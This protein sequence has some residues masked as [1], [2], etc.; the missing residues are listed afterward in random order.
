V[1]VTGSNPYNYTLTGNIANL[2]AAMDSL[3]ITPGQHN[4]EDITVTA[5][6]VSEETNPSEIGE[7]EIS[8]LSVTVIDKF[9]IPVEPQIL[10]NPVITL[11]SSF[12]N[13]TEDQQIELGR[14]GI[15]LDGSTDPDGSEVYFVEIEI[16][17]NNPEDQYTRWWVNGVE[18]ETWTNNVFDGKWLR[19]EADAVISIRAPT[20]F[21]GTRTLKMRATIVDYS[22]SGQ[23]I[24]VSE[25]QTFNVYV[26]PV[27][28][29][30]KLPPTNT[31]AVEDN[32]PVP[33]GITL[34]KLRVN[35][36]P[37]NLG[38]NKETE[39]IDSVVLAVPQNSPSTMYN[40]TFGASRTYRITSTILTSPSN[41]GSLSQSVREKASNDIIATLKAFQLEMGPRHSD[42][43]GQI[44]V[45][46][47]TLDVN[48]GVAS[49]NEISFNHDIIVL[50]VAD[51]ASVTIANT[52]TVDEDSGNT[53]P[54]SFTVAMSDDQDN[55][56]VL[57]IRISVPVQ[58]GSP[59]G[60]L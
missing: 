36:R 13:G 19:L 53:I 30:I 2:E 27:A 5:T 33:F 29:G 7:G 12:V 57:S 14:I 40:I 6:V 11:P 25:P 45:K 38:N 26:A 49:T 44:G 18:L 21:S 28:D 48:I 20:H 50:A 35:D 24:K 31:V 60:T 37:N 47:T 56:E 43:N 46:V 9:I 17:Y 8:V 58:N 52:P 54:L 34:S 42:S 59:V 32:G 23:A 39:T 41:K 51:K 10:G 3:K 4:G 1:A 22:M 15:S 16:D 55:S